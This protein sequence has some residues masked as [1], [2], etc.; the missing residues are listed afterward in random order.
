M[1]LSFAGA[2]PVEVVEMEKNRRIILQWA[3]DDGADDPAGAYNTT[4]TMWFESLDDDG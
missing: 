4:V 2:F 3:A 1:S